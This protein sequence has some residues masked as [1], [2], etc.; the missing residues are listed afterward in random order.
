MGLHAVPLR[1][2]SKLHGERVMGNRGRG[3]SRE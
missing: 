2:V 3:R 1:G